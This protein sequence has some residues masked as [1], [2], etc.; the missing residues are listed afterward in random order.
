MDGT[1][2]WQICMK[3]CSITEKMLSRFLCFKAKYIYVGVVQ[4]ISH[5]AALLTLSRS[6][7]QTT[8]NCKGFISA[9]LSEGLKGIEV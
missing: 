9:Y 6:C 1:V 5:L 8:T 2:N 4:I 3:L 7:T